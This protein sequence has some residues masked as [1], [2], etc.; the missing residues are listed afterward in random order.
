M[1]WE[2]RLTF[3]DFIIWEIHCDKIEKK[4]LVRIPHGVPSSKPSFDAVG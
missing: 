2:S 3:T 1:M 4:P